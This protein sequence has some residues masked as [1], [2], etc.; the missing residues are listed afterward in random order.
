MSNDFLSFYL[1]SKPSFFKGYGRLLDVSGS[2]NIYND[3]ETEKE[4]DFIALNND[5]RA[6]GHDIKK[7]IN[8][9]EQEKKE[10][11]KEYAA[12]KK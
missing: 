3:S 12:T 2:F 11:V 10:E 7:S 9:Y 1:F 8:K 6:V 4:A 5:W